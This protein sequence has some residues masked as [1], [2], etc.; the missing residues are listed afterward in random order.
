MAKFICV[1]NHIINL[2]NLP[3]GSDLRLIREDALEGI[4]SA[5]DDGKIISGETFLESLRGKETTV[6]RCPSCGRLHLD[7]SNDG[8]FTS[9]V[10][11]PR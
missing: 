4:I 1:C 10:K 9:Y 6:F 2:N 3:D 11:E 5:L 7:E 8:K